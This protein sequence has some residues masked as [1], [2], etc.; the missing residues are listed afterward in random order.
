MHGFSWGGS[1]FIY[2]SGSGYGDSLAGWRP[3]LS[4]S[5]EKFEV[6]G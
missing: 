5:L 1:D 6:I 2:G 3:D 4:M